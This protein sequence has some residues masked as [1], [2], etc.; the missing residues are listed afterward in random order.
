MTHRRFAGYGCAALLALC[1]A[2]GNADRDADAPLAFDDSFLDTS[3]DPCT[4]FYQFACGTWIAQHPAPAGYEV[5]RFEDGD[6]RDDIYFSQLVEAMSSDDARLRDAQSYYANCLSAP[7]A[8]SAPANALHTQLASIAAMTSMADL[9][10]TLANLQTSNVHALMEVNPEIDP[11]DPTRYSLDIFDDGWS[12]PTV[13]AYADA[14]LAAA[15]QAHMTALLSAATSADVNLTLDTQA[16]FDFERSVVLGA[17]TTTDPVAEYNPTDAAT[18]ATTLPGFDWAAYFAQL[19]FGSVAQANLSDPNYVGSLATLLASVPFDTVKQY[20]EWRVLEAD[21]NFIDEPLIDEEF[22]FHRTVLQGQAP[23]SGDTQFYCLLGARDAFG[24]AFAQHFVESFVPSTLKPSASALVDAVRSA[25]RSNFAQVSWLDDATRAA[26]LQKLDLLLP[27]VGY[28]DTWP[29]DQVGL[30]SNSSYLDQAIRVRQH[31]QDLAV[32]RLA[33]PVDRTEFWAS[34]EITNAFY[35][36]ARND[37]TIPVA[38]LQDPFFNPNRPAAF[39][40][41][42]LGQVVGHELT[43]GFDSNGRHFDGIG[44]LTDWWTASVATEFDHR[45][46]CLVDQFSSYEALPGENVNGQVTLNENIADLGGLKLAYAAFMAEPTRGKGSPSYSV[47]Q[48]FFLSYAQGWCSSVS[49]QAAAELLAT[50]VHSPP[51]FRVNGVVRNIPAFGQAFSCPANAPL[52][53][54]NACEVW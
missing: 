18:L 16:V 32:A 50:D 30:L 13:S 17:S 21:A 28:P 48:Q 35:S 9:P 22:H 43:H 36:P 31:A 53:P 37:I 41:G 15:Y 20:L 8:G 33:S 3:V 1:S 54:V 5:L 29:T 14:G 44:T 11:G 12:L 40:F 10:V 45:T 34:P 4:D 42:V 24:F 49:D 46:Q 51:K 38:V 25:M 26:A 23:S 7:L 27:K 6:Y 19:G 39:N 47:E 2:C 52:A